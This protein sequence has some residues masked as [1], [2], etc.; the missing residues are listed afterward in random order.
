LT[1]DKV[2]A[3]VG[4]NNF[5]INPVKGEY[6][7]LNKTQGH[8][9]KTVLFPV[10]SPL[11]GKGLLVSPTFFGNLLL[12]PTAHTI[13][14]EPLSPD[15]EVKTN[16]EI[17]KNIVQTARHSVPN[18]DVSQTLTSYAGL[19]AKSN[20]DDFI[21]EESSKV[22]GFINVAGID[23]PGLSS[24]PAIAALVLDILRTA[25]ERDGKVILPNLH[26]NPIRPSIIVRKTPE[27]KGA[28]DDPNPRK[29]IICRCETVT[30]IEIVDSLHRGIPVTGTDGVK[31]RTRA[32][33][34]FCQGRFCEPRVAKLISRELHIP[35]EKVGRRSKGTSILPH[36]RLTL[37]DRQLLSKL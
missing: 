28:I 10:P 4:A 27:W 22:Q 5:S 14:Q 15:D 17:I 23:S 20:T 37:E 36:Q 2:A 12:G 21:V 3:M 29:N 30:E 8:L 11:I 24:S 7:I 9:A 32:G 35:I 34:G 6:L 18:F 19:R 26:F 13:L 31:K 16:F 25:R 1:A 33:M